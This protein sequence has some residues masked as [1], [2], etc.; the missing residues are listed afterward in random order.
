MDELNRDILLKHLTKNTSDL[1]LSYLKP[2]P[3]KAELEEKTKRLRHYTEK[4]KFTPRLWFNG[5]HLYHRIYDLDG[6]VCAN[7]F[8]GTK[9]TF[10]KNIW[11]M[12]VYNGIESKE[13]SLYLLS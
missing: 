5:P 9:F 2:L 4:Y 1:I 3:F 6:N 8:Y 10:Y 13:L 12:S 11:S 7:S